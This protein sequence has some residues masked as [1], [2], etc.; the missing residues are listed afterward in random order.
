[1]MKSLFLK[2]EIMNITRSNLL[3]SQKM[4]IYMKNHLNELLRYWLK[5]YP[6]EH[7]FIG[8]VEDQLLEH[9]KSFEH[10]F[11]QLILT[12][13]RAV[14]LGVLNEIYMNDSGW[15]EWE[16]PNEIEVLDVCENNSLRLYRVTDDKWLCSAWFQTKNFGYIS[17]I[18]LPQIGHTYPSRE[19]AIRSKSKEVL[20]KTNEESCG[21]KVWNA[22][23]NLYESML[24]TTG[25]LFD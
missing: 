15:L 1:M 9:I 10:H 20:D 22:W 25:N 23:K 2:T 3:G 21:S 4:E 19:E 7:E 6:D 18:S 8:L 14:D 16:K 17:D 12:Y 24:D 11:Q 13:K 5:T